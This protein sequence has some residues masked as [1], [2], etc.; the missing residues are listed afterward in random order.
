[1]PAQAFSG[2]YPY[3]VHHPYDQYSMVD[4]ED[5]DAAQWP[6]FDRVRG[7]V[8]ILEPG[9]VLHVPRYW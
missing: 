5:V 4:F 6:L 3:P 7:Q 9:D 2:L 1:V 8:A